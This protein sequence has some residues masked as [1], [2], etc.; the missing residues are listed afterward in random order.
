M[1]AMTAT[2]QGPQEIPTIYAATP[3]FSFTETPSL[4]ESQA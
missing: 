4:I 1:T 2:A 3:F